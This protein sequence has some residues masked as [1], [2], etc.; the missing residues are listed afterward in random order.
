MFISICCNCIANDIIVTKNDGQIEAKLIEVS[1]T[2]LKYKKANYLDGPT[3][4][5][6]TN[7][8]SAI[9]YENGE[10]QT[11][12]EETTDSTK[13]GKDISLSTKNIEQNHPILL[14]SRIKLPNGK[15]R[16]R[17]HNK[18]YTIIM[19]SREFEKYIKENC[20]ISHNQI[21]KSNRTAVIGLVMD[22]VCLPV[23]LVLTIVSSYQLDMVLP[24]YNESCANDF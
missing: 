20:P 15:K 4:V 17:Y 5:I 16:Y 21:K 9:V 18:N 7:E 19:T 2:E 23:G 10:T 8:V 24:K 3:F 22:F 12:I 14:Y 6:K 11:F 1:K 13:T